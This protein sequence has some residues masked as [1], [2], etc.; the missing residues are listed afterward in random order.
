[1]L[2][3][4]VRSYCLL[5]LH[6]RTSPGGLGGRATPRTVKVKLTLFDKVDS[7]FSPQS[8]TDE[9]GGQKARQTSGCQIA[10]DR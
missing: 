8:L 6:S 3:F 10:R 7:G 1:M 9:S 4:Q 5:A 2:T